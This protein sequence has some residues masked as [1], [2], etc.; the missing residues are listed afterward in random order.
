MCYLIGESDSCFVGTAMLLMNN[1]EKAHLCFVGTA[2]LLMNNCE[3]A[4]L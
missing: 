4:H 1:Y 2:M 3:K